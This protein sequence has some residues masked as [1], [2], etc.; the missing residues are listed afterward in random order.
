VRQDAEAL[1]VIRTFNHIDVQF[2]A[3]SL[4]MKVHHP[5]SSGVSH[6]PEELTVAV[7][8]RNAQGVAKWNTFLNAQHNWEAGVKTGCLLSKDLP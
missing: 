2:G 1:D 8:I 7:L 3:K 5:R 6:A 4:G